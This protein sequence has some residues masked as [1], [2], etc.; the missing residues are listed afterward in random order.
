VIKN[1]FSNAVR[2]LLGASLAL[3]LGLPGPAPQSLCA[4]RPLDTGDYWSERD[5]L[6]RAHAQRL[7]KLAERCTQLNLPAQAQTTLRWIVP[8]DPRR[9]YLFLP[10]ESDP[11]KPPDDAPTIVR[12]WYR[13]FSEYRKQQADALFRL[14]KA[15]LDADRPARAYRLL[16][17]VLYQHPD[18]EAARRILGY[19]LVNGRWRRPEG[20]I[21]VRKTQASARTFGF[22]KGDYWVIDSGRFHLTT[23]HSEE[24]GR[25]LVQRL[26]D[27]SDVWRQLFFCYYS[28]RASLARRWDGKSSVSRS[29]KRHKIV[30]FRNRQEYLEH[31]QPIEPQI[32]V[33]VGYY[34]EA[35][36]TA[37]FYVDDQPRDDTYFHEVTHQLFS[38]TGRVAPGVGMRANAWI[39]EG[40]AMY[41]ESLRNRGRYY[42]SGG[43]DANRLQYARYRALSQHFYVPLEQLAAMGRRDLQQNENIRMLYSQSAGLTAMLMDYHRGVYQRALVDYLRA[44]YQG[45]DRADTLAALAGVPLDDLDQQY[46]EFLNVSDADLAALA[47]AEPVQNLSLGHTSVTD[48]GMKYLENETRL[49]WLDVGTT[50]VGDQGLAHVHCAAHLNHLIVEHTPITDAAMETIGQFREL[51]ILDLTGTAITDRGLAHL[52]SLV[53]LKELWLGQT[54]ITDAGLA[55]LTGLKRLETL[56]VGGTQVTG[57]GWNRLK[58]VLP[59][60]NTEASP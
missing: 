3:W 60:L 9:Q 54:A 40:A 11:V 53:K 1:R 58:K 37:Y 51:E 30:L 25:Q 13:K 34:L 15:Q 4:Q 16:H 18:H 28:N 23:D 43:I 21:R 19:R 33:S 32:A 7:R 24:A 41:M 22:P 29:L 42:T 39:I 27:L 46:M 57:E 6:D 56:D 10:P 26:D 50:Q 45:R 44:V 14:A 48:R 55:Y 31:L 12:Q 59:A 8:R 38:E 49:E 35:Q 52:K 5:A 47:D 20:T 17:E 36:K 2:L